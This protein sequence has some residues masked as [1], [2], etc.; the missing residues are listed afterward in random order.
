MEI[1]VSKSTANKIIDMNLLNPFHSLYVTERL[2]EEE[3]VQVVSP[4]LANQAGNLFADGNTVL[5]GTQ[6]SGKTTLLALLKGVVA[7]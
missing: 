5:R 4:Y 7:Q 6:G 2:S 1:F 3:F